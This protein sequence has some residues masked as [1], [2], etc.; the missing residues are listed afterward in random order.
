MRTFF[1]IGSRALAIALIALL[2]AHTKTS[3]A[4]EVHLKNGMVIEGRSHWI[5]SLDASG[6]RSAGEFS[7]YTVLLIDAGIKRYFVHRRRVNDINPDAEL[8]RLENFEVSQIMRGRSKMLA[9]VGRY[10]SVTPFT[11]Y[12]RRTVTLETLDGPIPI[13]QGVIAIGPKYLKIIGLK[14]VWELGIA[15]TS[16]NPKIL[17]AMIRQVT[18]QAKPEDRLAIARFYSQA[19]MYPR[20]ECELE[21]I[22]KDFT[23]LAD[24]VKVMLVQVH[25]LLTRQ[26]L[27]ELKHRKEAGQHR[28]A[29]SAA[30]I[31][32]AEKASTAVLREVRELISE[33][34]VAQEQASKTLALLGELRSQLTH[35]KQI[36]SV[37]PMRSALREQLDYETL[38]RLAAFLNLEG[39]KSLSPDEKLALAYSGWTLGTAN[40]ITELDQAIRIWEARF[41]IMEYLRTADPNERKM[42][43]VKLQNIEG[44]GAKTILQLIPQIPPVLETPNLE[45]GKA[46]E[47]TVNERDDGGKQSNGT[48]IP[49]PGVRYSVLLPLEY[50]HHHRYP[51]IVA[52]RAEG[53]TT[54]KQLQWWGGTQ[55]KPLQAQRHGYI[56]I[57][58]EYAD[59]NQQNYDYSSKVH[60]IVIQA[61]R[62]ARKRFNVDSDRIFLAGHGM[63][64]D[65]AFD[66]GMTHPDLFAGV[67]PIT[68]VS[69][70]YCKYYV[71]NAERLP[72]YVVGGELD[73]DTFERNLRRRIATREID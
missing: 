49:N 7:T 15:T 53:R 8:S 59:K 43:L 40:A 30:K 32:P 42:I 11:K 46:I 72:W 66:I 14:E 22:A 27:T 36:D 31:F 12:G 2:A 61:I 21:S 47:I 60:Y 63:G 54:A 67:I 73:R 48:T 5:Q 37:A 3:F 71:S 68:G 9:R 29:Y 65:A 50:H 16:I 38:G 45:P 57:A 13:I 28:L 70:K 18:D 19:E 44:V 6:R 17:D 26:L 56:V 25:Q 10:A 51:M 41:L 62:D 24:R 4:G 55:D 69:D 23:E 34:D 1:E 33:Y 20:S 35:R 58:P 52:L 64:G 39:D